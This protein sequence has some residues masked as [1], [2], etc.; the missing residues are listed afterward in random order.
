[1]ALAELHLLDLRCIETARLEFGTGINL[2]YGANGAG[3][4]SLLEAVFLLGRGRSFRNRLNERLIRHGQ[5][6]SRVVGKT[7]PAP[8]SRADGS[9][10]AS[11]AIHTLGLEIR[12]EGSESGGTIA[13]LD[14]AA[15]RSMA[16]LALAFPVQA[17]DPDA[18]KLIEES[19][20]RRRRWLDWAVFHVEH[21]FAGA[22]S[23]YQRALQQRNAALRSGSREVGAWEPEMAREGES[24]TASRE[25]V[26]VAL[27]PYW[28]E[29][30]AELVGLDLTLGFQAGWDRS[31]SLAD[32]LTASTPRDRERHTTTTGPHRADVTLRLRGKLAREVLSRGQQKLAAVALHLCQLEYLKR[33]HGLLP[34]LLLDDP[35][36]ELDQDR[37]GRFI[38]RVQCLETQIIVTALERDTRLFGSPDRV[39]HV[40]QGRVEGG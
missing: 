39:F 28:A 33:E 30:S 5:S 22:W 4:T 29:I 36:A 23:R 10:T 17:L 15:A 21:S 38:R 24:L 9:L 7:H 3:K 34:T 1:M 6:V 18:H 12:R 25:R 37:L 2:I 14:G 40:E 31:A 11:G 27:Q 13:R 19:A 16:E 20:A 32:A 35:S 8:Q 26:M